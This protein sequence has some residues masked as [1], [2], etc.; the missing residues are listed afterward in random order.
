MNKGKYDRYIRI[1]QKTVTQDPDYGSQ[2]E[3]WSTFTNT[4]AC[5]QDITTNNQER[6]NTDL[7]QLTRPCKIETPYI[8]GIDATMRVVLLDRDNRLLQIVSLPAEL[9]R[10]DA[11]EFMAEEFVTGG[12]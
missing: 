3:T 11:I 1:E 8:S 4:W 2:I 5:V 10:K 9:G 6:T 7:R 12:Q